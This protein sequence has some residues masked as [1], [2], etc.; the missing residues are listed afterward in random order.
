MFAQE[1][2]CNYF[3][4]FTFLARARK[5]FGHCQLCQSLKNVI[6]FIYHKGL[7]NTLSVAFYFFCWDILFWTSY[8]QRYNIECKM[9]HVCI[10]FGFY[11]V[12]SSFFNHYIQSSE[13]K[14][15]TQ[16]LLVQPRYEFRS[17]FYTSV[18]KAV[19]ACG[20]LGFPTPTTPLC[21]E[22]RATGIGGKLSNKGG[23][24]SP[25]GWRAPKST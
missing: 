25:V 17:R 6:S 1:D 7:G 4:S 22:L 15:L 12:L 2:S 20:A 16:P 21:N 9:M 10:W 24:L 8:F 18:V 19:E 11:W 13:P 5:K 3:A 14:S 23:V